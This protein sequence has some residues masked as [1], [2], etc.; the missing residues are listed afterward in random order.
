MPLHNCFEDF[1]LYTT[2]ENTRK[3]YRRKAHKTKNEFL[4]N[5]REKLKH[6]MNNFPFIR[7]WLHLKFFFLPI[8]NYGGNAGY[9]KCFFSCVFCEQLE[10]F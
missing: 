6:F 8:I 1:S 4:M 2:V 7:T 5:S 3:N 9:F 10:F